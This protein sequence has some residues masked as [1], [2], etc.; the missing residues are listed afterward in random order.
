MPRNAQGEFSLVAGNPV[1]SGTPV[2]S[3]THNSTMSDLAQGIRDSLDRNGR[4]G[5]LVPFKLPDG[6]VG[7]PAFAFT[8]EPATGMYRAGA[9]D[10]RFAVVG[11]DVLKLTGAAVD[12]QKPLTVSGNTAWH[13]G[14]D[15][16]A[17]GLD[18]DLLDAQHGAYYLDLVNA[19]GTLAAAR[20]SAA[21]I[22]TA[23]GYTPW[24]AGND[25]AGSGLD[26]D[27]L[28]GV[29]LGAAS[30]FGQVWPYI[31]RVHT[32]GGME[33]GA[34]LDFHQAS[35]ESAVNYK[36]RLTSTGDNLTI[37]GASSAVS[38]ISLGFTATTCD[39][40]LDA[41]T[42]ARF[43]LRSQAVVGAE[44]RALQIETDGAS[45]T[46]WSPANLGWLNLIFSTGVS[47]SSSIR[48]GGVIQDSSGNTRLNCNGA[49]TEN[50]YTSTNGYHTFGQ[51]GV[52]YRH[53]MAVDGSFVCTGNITAYG[54]VSDERLKTGIRPVE[55]ALTKVLGLRAVTH[56]WNEEALSQTLFSPTR[57]RIHGVIAQ[58]VAKVM[59]DAVFETAGTAEKYLGVRY[60]RLTV[61]LLAAVQEL[62]ER[63][64]AVGVRV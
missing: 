13:A 8:S 45:S 31:P 3:T 10:F 14:N 59:P 36:H 1:V 51:V 34:F 37:V 35:N 32:D 61:L 62:T 40:T 63:L 19:T 46:M 22:I 57:G 56:E 24:H 28:D 33:V 42:N 4:G 53:Q 18:A 55:G 49:N 52:A 25:G 50:Y 60:E 9:S 41:P 29:D 16:A 12:V 21:N 64:R 48:L 6:A 7:A 44:K 30:T 5:M 47:V 39:L 38:T 23:L 26:A 15:G 54:S 58:D 20:M 17:S 27:L 11:V 2:S 43:F